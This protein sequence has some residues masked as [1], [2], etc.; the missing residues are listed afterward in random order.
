MGGKNK[1][2]RRYQQRASTSNFTPKLS[3]EDICELVA[4]CT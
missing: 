1:N 3:E 2:K 4:Q